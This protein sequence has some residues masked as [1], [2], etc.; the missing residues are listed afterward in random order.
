[1]KR[2]PRILLADDHILLLAAFEQ[3]LAPACEVVGRVADGRALLEAAPRL[4]PDVVVLDIS[5]PLLNG[6]DACR[7][8][9]PRLPATRWVFLTVNQDPDLAA[10][11]FRLGGSAYL[12]KSSAARELFTAIETAMRGGRYV[13]PLITRGEPLGTFLARTGQA[14][15]GKLT[16][17]QR[18]V[19]QLLAEGRLMKEVA[20]LLHVTPRT[21]AFHK[22]SVMQHLGVKTNAELIQQAVKLRL[23]HP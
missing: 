8:L 14:P 19:L 15:A 16:A 18:E 20:D 7:Q 13:T 11:A 9:K 23:V 10:E 3:L 22:Y 6:L 5:M 2:R 1:M 12:L 21:V 4:K 17:R